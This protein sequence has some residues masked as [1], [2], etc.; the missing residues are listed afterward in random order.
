MS[1][2]IFSKT[3]TESRKT[4]RRTRAQRTL[5]RERYFLKQHTHEDLAQDSDFSVEGS[6]LFTSSRRPS[7]ENYPSV[8]YDNINSRITLQGQ[9]VS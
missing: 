6:P 9:T 2:V 5:R 4:S 7:L 3:M 1:K 8:L